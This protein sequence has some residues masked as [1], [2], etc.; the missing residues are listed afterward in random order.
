M[1]ALLSWNARTCSASTCG[2]ASTSARSAA[3]RRRGGP[4]LVGRYLA[5]AVLAQPGRERV[6]GRLVP[7]RQGA[8]VLLRAHALRR[9]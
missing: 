8:R 6:H 4:A 1:M 7:L 9:P 5:H 3:C 2:S